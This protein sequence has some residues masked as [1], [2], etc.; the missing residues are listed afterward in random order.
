MS[1]RHTGANLAA[2]LNDC[3]EEF[4][5]KGGITACVHDNACNMDSAGRLCDKWENLPCFAHTLQLC[6]K[7]ALVI[8]EVEQTVTRCW[9]LVGHFPHSTTVTA[10]MRFSRAVMGLPDHELIQDVPTRWNSTQQ[11]LQRL[12]EQRLV[13]TDVMINTRLTK[14]NDR[15]FLLTDSEWE[16]ASD[17]AN[18]LRDLTVATEF[19]CKEQY[20]SSSDIYSE[21]CGLLTNSLGSADD[22]SDLMQLVKECLRDEMTRR[23]K[24]GSMDTAVA[25][26]AIYIRENILR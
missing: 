20:V 22:D 18:T 16:I 10:E 25:N 7:P 24:P 11:M 2:G 12:V 8:E 1:E 14:K 21:V 4:Q 15:A 26:I 23:F 17:I 5:L 3:V 6:I 13:V 19:M 9:K